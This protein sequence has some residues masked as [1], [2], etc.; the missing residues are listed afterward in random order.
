VVLEPNAN[1]FDDSRY[2]E[3][4]YSDI[5]IN[6]SISMASGKQGNTTCRGSFRDLFVKSNFR[7]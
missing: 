1:G 2:F 3:I 5:P 6:M 4:F 7:D